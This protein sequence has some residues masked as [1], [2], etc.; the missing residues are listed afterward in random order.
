MVQVIKH[1]NEDFGQEVHLQ[2]KMLNGVNQRID[3]THAKMTRM[4]DRLKS[5]VNK[6]STLFYY[7]VIAVEILAIILVMNM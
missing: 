5:M 7:G 1:E 3:K 2:T 6:R 4:N